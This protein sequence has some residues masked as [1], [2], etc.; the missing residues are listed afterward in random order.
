MINYVNVPGF[1]K[2]DTNGL[3]LVLFS[4]GKD[5][6]TLIFLAGSVSDLNTLAGLISSGTLQDCVVQGQVAV[7]KLSGSKGGF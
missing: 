6:N 5:R 7:C 4:P 2:F 3:G 1:G